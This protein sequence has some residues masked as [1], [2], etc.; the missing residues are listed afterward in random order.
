MLT[1]ISQDL[2]GFENLAGLHRQPSLQMKKTPILLLLLVS[3]NILSA[4]ENPKEKIGQAI[5]QYFDLDRETIHAHFDKS[6][7]FTS[8]EIW[9]KGYCY[10]KKQGTPFFETTNVFAVLLDDTGKQI[11]EQLVF[12]Y[13]GAFSGSIKLGPQLKSGQYYVRFYTNWMNNF[14]EDESAIYPL[15]VINENE[16][17]V[18]Q[19]DIPDYSKI[20]I[21][22]HPEGGHF[23]DGVPNNIGIRVTDCGGNPIETRE[24]KIVDGKGETIS[25]FLI[26]KNGCGKT[27]LTPD[28]TQLKAVVS[29]GGKTVEA[30]L[31]QSVNGIAMEVNNYAL[32]GK[33]IVKLRGDAKTLTRYSTKPL[34]VVVQQNNKSTVFETTLKPQGTELI[35]TNDNLYPGVNTIR[36]IDEKLEELAQRMICEIPDNPQEFTFSSS[37]TEQGHKIAG[38]SNFPNADISISVLPEQSI[39]T[40]DDDLSTAFLV[41]PYLKQPIRQSG[42]FFDN[43]TKAKCYELDLFLLN[44]DS[45]RYEWR[46]ISAAP[47]KTTYD[48]DIGLAIKGTINQNLPDP[49]KYRMLL[50]SPLS[51]IN[52]YSAIDEKKA[53]FFP[54]LVFANVS[55]F[56]FTLMKIPSFAIES[57]FIHQVQ[58]R[59]RPFNKPFLPDPPHC[60]PG[61]LV[62]LDAPQFGKDVIALDNI[63]IA[64]K[65][66]SELK[67]R[68]KFGNAGLRGYKIDKDYAGTS[69][70]TFIESNGFNVSR[71][72]GAVYITG[73]LRTTVNGQQSTPEI[74]INSRKLIY[75][76]ELQDINM[77]DVDEIYL[78][79]H[80]IVA[81]MNNNAGIIKIY[82]KKIDYGNAKQATKNFEIKE[83]FSPIGKFEPPVYLS[84]ADK[85]FGKYGIIQWVPTVLT[86]SNGNFSFEIPKT[87]TKTVTLHIQGFTPEG[88]TISVHKTISLQ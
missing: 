7:F 10:N 39:A 69:L 59:K 33:T 16:Q 68:T 2:R 53:F 86:D 61:R 24:A 82:M 78:N 13:I 75:F 56:K 49:K 71:N 36:V 45:G 46:N 58:N 6:V 55:N 62:P 25:N 83:G 15:Q 14:P 27:Y 17:V 52:D 23:V 54:N 85:G 64:G 38:H 35:F 9:F 21:S 30:M 1:F 63:E 5:A 11:S 29:A 40:A 18:T 4:Q 44:Q 12:S 84:T 77:D 47:N 79:A 66:K 31:P 80:A 65:A 32:P 87:D 73:R 74:Y 48:F 43:P 34:F 22:F 50:S 57:T 67:Y 41:N 26:G 51:M 3:C 88:K 8:E 19:Y 37:K 70:L 72:M 28:N 42:Q 76:D 81:S 60:S 20:N